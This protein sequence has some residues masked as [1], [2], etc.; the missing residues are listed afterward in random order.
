M[1]GVFVG[2]KTFVN[3]TISN[4]FCFVLPPTSVARFVAFR[5]VLNKATRET[6]YWIAD[7]APPITS[8]WSY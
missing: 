8:D 7:S 1:A 6:Y 3:A 2:Q 5:R 4:F